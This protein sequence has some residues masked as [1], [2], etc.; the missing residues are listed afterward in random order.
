[1]TWVGCGPLLARIRFVYSW[2]EKKKMQN[3]EEFVNKFK[4]KLTTDDCYTPEPIYNAVLEWCRKEYNLNDDVPIVRPFFPGGDYVHFEYPKNCVVI[5]NPPFSIISK[6]V[7]F[8]LDNGIRFFL[9][10]PGL[11]NL[12][13][14]LLLEGKPVTKIIAG[15]EITYTN[16][17]RVRTGFVTNLE[18]EYWI[19]GSRSLREAITRAAPPARHHKSSAP[20]FVMTNARVQTALAHDEEIKLHRDEWV[21]VAKAGGISVYGGGFVRKDVHTAKQHGPVDKEL[22][23]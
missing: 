15:C 6:I 17:A 18:T 21:P 13:H 19:R 2:R 1:M 12:S 4:P 9:F 3:Y 10:A 5:D 22:P 11:M 20:D 23:N 7:K 14:K 8:Y 16:G